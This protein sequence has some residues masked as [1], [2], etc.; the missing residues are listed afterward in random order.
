[1]RSRRMHG[2]F[3]MGRG[4]A[5]TER[6]GCHRRAKLVLSTCPPGTPLATRTPHCLSSRT[7]PPVSREPIAESDRAD[8]DRPCGEPPDDVAGVVDSKVDAGESDEQ[9]ERDGREPDR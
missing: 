9:D 5:P 2:P 3:D 1:M 6:A 4:P 8:P 7:P